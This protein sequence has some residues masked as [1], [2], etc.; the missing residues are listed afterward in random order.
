VHEDR[1]AAQRRQPHRAAVDGQAGDRR[2]RRADG[3]PGSVLAGSDEPD[4]D[5]DA[6]G[7]K[8]GDGEREDDRA[9]AFRDPGVRR[10][11]PYRTV[12]VPVIVGIGWMEQM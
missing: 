3:D 12:S 6:R 7:R 1:L 9:A 2:R 11:P 5:E 10:W 4:V 8:R